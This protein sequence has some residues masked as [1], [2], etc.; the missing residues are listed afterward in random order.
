LYIAVNTFG[1]IAFP[2][3]G[4]LFIIVGLQLK[5]QSVEVEKQEEIQIEKNEL[6]R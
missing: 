4:G 3:T 6:R 2:G 5:K 1:D